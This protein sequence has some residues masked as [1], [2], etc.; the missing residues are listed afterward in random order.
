MTVQRKQRTL[1]WEW[2]QFYNT[3]AKSDRSDIPAAVKNLLS[4]L[5]FLQPPD[6]YRRTPGGHA[7]C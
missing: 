4:N 1:P 6:L 2:N 5:I 3:S 7:D